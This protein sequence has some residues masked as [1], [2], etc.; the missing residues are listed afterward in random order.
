[1]QGAAADR[2]KAGFMGEA[3]ADILFRNRK[4]GGLWTPR[5]LR[6][7]QH[8]SENFAGGGGSGVP[9]YR[10]GPVALRHA[11]TGLIGSGVIMSCLGHDIHLTTGCSKKMHG[12][13][14]F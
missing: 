8:V 3:S 7:P 11:V 1:M 4:Y 9:G 10:C 14:T 12:V 2:L 5:I 13:S 6:Q